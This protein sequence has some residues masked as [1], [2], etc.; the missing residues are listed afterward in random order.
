[1]YLKFYKRSYSQ[2]ECPMR[3]VKVNLANWPAADRRKLLRSLALN[4]GEVNWQQTVLSNDKMTAINFVCSGHGGILLFSLEKLNW[5]AELSS[6]QYPNW[7]GLLPH[8][9]V[10]EFEEDCAW[11]VFY[12]ALPDKLKIKQWGNG[13]TIE[14]LNEYAERSKREYFPEEKLTIPC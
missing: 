9:Y 3:K 8:F 13:M 12:L 11:A 4:W 5:T 14:R 7:P 10:Y 2:G 1:M 6:E